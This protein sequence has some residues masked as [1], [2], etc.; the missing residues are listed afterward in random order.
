MLLLNPG[1]VSREQGPGRLF[2]RNLQQLGGSEFSTIW[3]FLSLFSL[4]AAEFLL[5]LVSAKAC[6]NEFSCLLHILE[7]RGKKQEIMSPNLIPIDC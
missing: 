2:T 7:A 1:E 3:A 5:F 6:Y 4:A